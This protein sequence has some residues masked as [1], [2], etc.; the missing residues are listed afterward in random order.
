MRILRAVG[1][2]VA[3]T[4]VLALL[5]LVPAA[6]APGGTSVWTRGWIFLAVMGLVLLGSTVA[7]A[8]W[9]PESFEVRRRPLVAGKGQKQPLIDAVGLPIYLLYVVGWAA[10]IPLDVF[11]LHLL[12]APSLAMSWA[13]A[14]LCLAGIGIG[15][16]AVAQNRFAAPTIH[17]QSAERQQV[18]DT[19]L[20]GLIR[21]PL[22][23]GNLLMFSG[24]ALWL[25][26][27]AALIGVSAM[28]VATLWR[29]VI[30][31]NYLQANLPGY[32]DYRRRVRGR[33]VP[34]LL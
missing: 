10:F 12:P 30:E 6:L 20:Y 29:I 9:A 31:E 25:G 3:F 27:Y 7:L 17:D 23:A 16:L 11:W 18:V 22:Y 26:S 5:L 32:D 33:L 24:M 1:H 4:A 8:V 34:F 14:A 2:A 15:Q 21:H 13:G 28:L 19:G